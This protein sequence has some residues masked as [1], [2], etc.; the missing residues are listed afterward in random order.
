MNNEARRTVDG[1]GANASETNTCA[2]LHRHRSI[3]ETAGG[4]DRPPP[5]DFESEIQ[6]QIHT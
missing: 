3:S 6:N 1:E 2:A 5:L 4:H